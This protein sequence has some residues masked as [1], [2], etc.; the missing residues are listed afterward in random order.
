MWSSR[1]RQYPSIVF[2]HVLF[3]SYLVYSVVMNQDDCLA[4]N[5]GTNITFQNNKCSGG[6]GISI[7]SIKSDVTVS[8][9]R[10]LNNAVSDSDNCL[11]IKMDSD[12][13]DSTVSGVTHTGNTCTTIHKYG[14]LIDQSYP[15]TLGTPGSGVILSV[16]RLVSSSD[17]DIDRS[18]R[19]ECA[20]YFGEYC[21]GGLRRRSR[22]GE[23]WIQWL[24]GNLELVRPLHQRRQSRSHQL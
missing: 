2:L 3:S 11:R 16:S 22:S 23:L 13:D 9:I 21:L 8:T 15:D 17:D 18:P 24:H 10:I 1:T 4:I 6:H 12:A 19:A 5:K 20:I 7:G 14:V